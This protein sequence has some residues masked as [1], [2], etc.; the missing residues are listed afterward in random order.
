VTAKGKVMCA[1][2]YRTAGMGAHV[3]RLVLLKEVLFNHTNC[4][5][6]VL[7]Y[8]V[9]WWVI[10]MVVRRFLVFSI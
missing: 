1:R 4:I 5:R 8:V 7:E 6:V 2:V 3:H 9:K 10:I